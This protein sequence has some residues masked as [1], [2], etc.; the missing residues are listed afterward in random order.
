[1]DDIIIRPAT[2]AD[3]TAIGGLWKKLADHHQA[4]DPRLP[5]P[6]RF[7]DELYANRI[8][9]QLDDAYHQVL[10]ADYHEQIVGYVL[11]MIADYM[12]DIFVAESTG[13]LADIFVDEAHRGTGVGKKLVLALQAWF[14]S[15]GIVTMEWYVA[16]QNTSAKAF[17]EHIGGKN[18][19]IRMRLDL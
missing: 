17:W 1:M 9:S 5:K 8:G 7:G 15:R 14:K 4:L 13:F 16:A 6:A 19:I 11:G 10:V 18:L 12:P 2:Q 3:I